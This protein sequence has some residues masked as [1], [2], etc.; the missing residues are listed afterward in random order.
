MKTR[1][2]SPIF[3]TTESKSKSAIFLIILLMLTSL[4]SVAFV[5]SAMAQPEPTLLDPLTIPKYVD[6][7]IIPP[8]YV[9]TYSVQFNPFRIVQNYKVDMSEFYQQILPTVDED[10]NPTGFGPTKVWGYGGN[11]RDAVTRK[12]LG[13]VRNS[14]GP[15]FEIIRGIPAK[16]TWQNKITTPHMFAVDPTLHW[17]N[18]NGMPMMLDPPFPAFP[19]GFEDAQANVTLVTHLHGGEVQSDFDGGPDQWWTANG[20]RGPAYSSLVPATPDSALYYYPNEQLPTTLW[21]HDHALGLTRINVMSGLAGFYLLRDL[22]DPVGWLLPKGKY[23]IPIAI[24]DRIFDTDGQIVFPHD[25]ANPDIH[26]YWLPEFFGNAIMV[27]GKMWP[28]L[29]VDKGQYRFRVLDGSNARFYNFSLTVVGTGATLPFTLIG[30]DQGYL[31]SAV[32]LDRLVIAPGERADILV[33]FSGLA[34]GTKIRMTNTAPAPFPDGAPGDPLGDPTLADFQNTVGQIMQ[35]TVTANPGLRPK[36]LPPILNPTLV[37]SFPTLHAPDVTRTLP[38]FELM[39]EIDE[40]L[41]VFLNG[42]K[43]AGVMTE[44]PQVGATEDWWLVNPTGDAHPIHLHL[45]QF[46]LLY[47][48]PFDAIAYEVDW[49][50]L[51]GPVPVPED[52]IPTELSVIPYLTGPPI[53]PTASERVWKDTIQAPPGFVTVIRVRFA[54]QKAPVTGPRAP[55]PGINK[56]PFDPTLGPGYV[57]HCHIIDHEDNEM[58]RPYKVLP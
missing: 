40:P 16:V 50:A 23:E 41:G 24:Q 28:N 56:Y 6:Q 8:V 39:S 9:P 30:S 35:F 29:N 19:P 14:P 55:S 44:M 20:L 36:L 27:N 22:L 18:P 17:A 48:I 51:N 13:Y 45:V 34:S 7:L 1:I 10:G 53:L 47:R 21:Y 42:Q 25:G 31:K 26:P 37:G 4:S 38:F 12:F 5:N 2:I 58:M 46:Q 3:G 52:T 43:W 11:V 54:P 57:W 15:S 32:T 33:D 49:M